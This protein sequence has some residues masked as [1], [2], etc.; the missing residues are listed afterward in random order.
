MAL[1]GLADADER[2]MSLAEHRVHRGD[3]VN[4]VVN[5]SVCAAVDRPILHLAAFQKLFDSQ[6][7]LIDIGH[8]HERAPH[9]DVLPTG[10]DRA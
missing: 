3:G 7:T 10:I 4:T 9:R 2:V 6:G 8:D 5:Q 1:T